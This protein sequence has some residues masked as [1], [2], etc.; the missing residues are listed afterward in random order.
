MG[1]LVPACRDVVPA[2][3]RGR[4]RHAAARSS[5]AAGSVA[6]ILAAAAACRVEPRMRP[7]P[8]LDE[9]ARRRVAERADRFFDEG[10]L[11][12]PRDEDGPEEARV[13]APLL[14]E[15]SAAADGTPLRF[16]ALGREHGMTRVSDEPTVYWLRSTTSVADRSRERWTYAWW[17]ATEEGP[18]LRG[19]RMTLDGDGFP[20]VFEILGD[21]SGMRPVYVTPAL[22]AAASAAWGAPL[23]GRGFAI[24]RAV[25]EAPDVV[26]IELIEPGPEP[27]GPFVYLETGTRDVTALI[28]R[29]MPSRVAEITNSAT[30]RLAPAD[31]TPDL[32]RELA[33][34]PD[35]GLDAM[36][37]LPGSF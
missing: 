14:I 28:C 6:L 29:C 20:V 34:K 8:A 35:D 19:T 10:S 1:A 27:L 25:D 31:A 4:G 12:K 26:V 16:G 7:E 15:E 11:W 21:S 32:L 33:A 36:L 13:L 5:L 24:E 23:P 2:T 17:Y 22:E 37:R 9:A 30:Y 3:R 18:A